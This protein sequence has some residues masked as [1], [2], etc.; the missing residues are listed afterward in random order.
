VLAGKTQSIMCT[1]IAKGNKAV[2]CHPYMDYEPL[3]EGYVRLLKIHESPNV[4]NIEKNPNTWDLGGDIKISLISVPL[5]ESPPYVALSYTWG[6]PGPFMDP[7]TSIFT[8][9]SRCFPIKCRGKLILGTRNLINAVR[10]LRQYEYIQK[11][12]PAGTTLDK[13]ASDLSWY[14]KN[15][16]LYWIDAICIDQDDLQE[17]SA[18]VLLMGRIYRQAQCTMAWLGER[19]AYTAAALQALMK[20]TSYN[21]EDGSIIQDIPGTERDKFNGLSSLDDT[22]IEAL[23]MLMARSWFSRTWVLQEAV[24]SPSVVVILASL[25]VGFDI[26]LKAGT[27]LNISRSS[28]RLLGFALRNLGGSDSTSMIST[29]EDRIL[30]TPIVLAA[31]DSCR[32]ELEDGQTPDF[33]TAVAMCRPCQATDPRDR[34]YG[35]L[36]MAR[37]FDARNGTAY[38]PDYSLTVEEVYTSATASVIEARG[39]LACLTL[40]CDRSLQK[41]SNFPSWCPDYSVFVAP[42]RE[43]ND[44]ARMWRLGLSWPDAQGPKVHEASLLAVEGFRFDVVAEIATLV[45][46]PKTSQTKHGVAAIF[47]L[48]VQLNDHDDP[49]SLLG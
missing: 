42:L 19:D 45:E 47:N 36:A 34:I 8:Q 2:K 41:S 3:P 23:T 18:Q 43:F 5:N 21:P 37:E 24:I 15:T 4:W 39:D 22:E 10:R 35:I 9:I 48:A 44:I 16:H 26:F 38:R 30:R 7:T 28:A 31:I 14:N 1:R 20:I 46:D 13:M 11:R 27:V 25:F 33:M 12:A 17:R 29:T 32:M 49:D 40:V 6:E